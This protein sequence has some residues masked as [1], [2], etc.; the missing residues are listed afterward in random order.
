M[1][2]FTCI[3]LNAPLCSVLHEDDTSYIYSAQSKKQRSTTANLPRLLRLRDNLYALISRITLVS[4][5]SS[6][7]PSS[8]MPIALEIRLLLACSGCMVV[9]HGPS[10]VWISSHRIDYY[11]LSTQHPDVPLN[12]VLFLISSFL[13]QYHIFL[14]RTILALRFFK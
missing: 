14:L 9:V 1:G 11:T 6:F 5:L 12:G 4:F 10:S 8:S 13:T 2:L 7:N 3:V